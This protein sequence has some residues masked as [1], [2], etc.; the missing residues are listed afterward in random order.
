MNNFNH[1]K[2]R[3][4]DEKEICKCNNHK[5]FNCC[6]RLRTNNDRVI[7]Y[8]EHNYVPDI[9]KL[10]CRQFNDLKEVAKTTQLSTHDVIGTI[11]S[12]VSK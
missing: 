3:N 4:G 11:T 12:K 8:V 5:E 1:R 10:K 6:S 9:A 7:K 2:Y